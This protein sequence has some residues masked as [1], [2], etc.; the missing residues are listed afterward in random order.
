MKKKED[1]GVVDVEGEGQKRYGYRYG[2]SRC[3]DGA[4]GR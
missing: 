1:A 2:F 4:V 3:D